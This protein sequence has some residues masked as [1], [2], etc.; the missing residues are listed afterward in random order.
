MGTTIFQRLEKKLDNMGKKAEREAEKRVRH[1]RIIEMA[2]GMDI[3]EKLKLI[4][5]IL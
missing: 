5:K 4:T 2:R 3:W 1:E